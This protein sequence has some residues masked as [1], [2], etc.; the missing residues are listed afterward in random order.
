MV[1]DLSGSP[2]RERI[3]VRKMKGRLPAT[4][5]KGQMHIFKERKNSNLV[6]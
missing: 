4:P 2:T 1:L 6:L 5:T 3:R